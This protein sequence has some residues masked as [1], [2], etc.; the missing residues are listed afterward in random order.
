M[1]FAVHDLDQGEG[2]TSASMITADLDRDG[3]LDLV[4]KNI[5]R[6]N[7]DGKGTFGANRL[8]AS[9]D[10]E[11]NEIEAVDVDGDGDLDLVAVAQTSNFRPE[12]DLRIFENRDGRG[13]FGLPRTINSA[14]P[15]GSSLTSG[16]TDND[17]DVDLVLISYDSSSLVT[18]IH[19]Y[20]NTD[21]RGSFQVRQKRGNSLTGKVRLLDVDA[22]GDLDLISALVDYENTDGKGTFQEKDLVPN[23]WKQVFRDSRGIL[24][25]LTDHLL[26]ER[27]A[28]GTYSQIVVSPCPTREFDVELVRMTDLN[29]DGVLDRV[30][31]VYLNSVDTTKAKVIWCQGE[32][33]VPQEVATLVDYSQQPLLLEDVTG[34]GVKDILYGTAYRSIDLRAGQFGP[35]VALMSPTWTETVN[36]VKLADLDQDGDLDSISLATSYRPLQ[37]WT[38]Q[39]ISWNEN[40]DGRGTFGARKPIGDSV[41]NGMSIHRPGTTNFF[42]V[43]IDNDQDLDVVYERVAGGTNVVAQT[44][45]GRGQF[46]NALYDR[47]FEDETKGVLW[48]VRPLESS[49]RA[50]LVFLSEEGV[51]VKRATGDGK[52]G[53]LETLVRAPDLFANAPPG[54]VLAPMDFNVQLVDWDR[55]GDLDL[56]GVNQRYEVAWWENLNDGTQF[57]PRIPLFTANM[58]GLP[59]LSVGLSVSDL[60]GDQ[61]LDVMLAAKTCERICTGTATRWFANLDGRTFGPA[62]PIANS[63]RR[64][65]AVDMDRDG[66]L[67]ILGEDM[68]NA[69][70]FQ[71][72]RLDA[73][74][75]ENVGGT[76]T[77]WTRREIAGGRQWVVAAGDIDGDGDVDILAP[78]L[79]WYEQRL[80]GDIN[81][82]GRFSSSD[83]VL[84]FQAGLYDNDVPGRAQFNQGDFNGDGNFDSTDLIFA[85]QAGDYERILPFGD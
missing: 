64:P 83:L 79:K 61:D 53:P 65:R 37:M 22:D 38:F 62:V 18:T 8:F 50:D 67:D 47:I 11:A 41:V 48:D 9:D 82:D 84:A 13:D 30:T 4:S 43:D 81:N 33:D 77:T 26:H 54:Y 45:D 2:A 73:A 36:E 16:D 56:M 46:S 39:S 32:Q 80:S 7:L 27:L 55:D 3:D 78:N 6:E 59:Y 72:E 19:W 69:D 25:V 15:Y 68:S 24:N 17:G 10:Y 35:E 42:V 31:L 57:G 28:D 60:D 63:I 5:W 1:G 70:S 21:G 76:G 34:D 85:F 58:D 71:H 40:L 51:S 75:Y 52:F 49:D 44:N 12:F 66:D 74:W 29:G 20:E 14:L 23:R